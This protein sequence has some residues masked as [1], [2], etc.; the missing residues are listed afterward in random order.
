MTGKHR[1]ILRKYQHLAAR[2]LL[3]LQ[4]EICELEYEYNKAAQIDAAEKRNERQYYDRDWLHLAA[5]QRRNFGG[6]QWAIA[7]AMR[8]KLREYCAFLPLKTLGCP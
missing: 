4:A 2:D 3:Y 7:L 6:E 5:S 8:E 1:P